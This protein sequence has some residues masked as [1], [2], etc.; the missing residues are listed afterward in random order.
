VVNRNESDQVAVRAVEWDEQHVVGLPFM[1]R[2][3]VVNKRA[4]KSTQVDICRDLTYC[5]GRHEVAAAEAE[6]FVEEPLR[7]LNREWC[8][9]NALELFQRQTR[10]DYGV[11]RRRIVLVNQIEYHHAESCG[12][13]DTE[14]D[15]L[16]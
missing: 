5:V 11:Q 3:H 10:A 6:L 12:F 15:L 16:Q 14:R 1:G 9:A 8:L 13:D 4:A 7:K 2:S